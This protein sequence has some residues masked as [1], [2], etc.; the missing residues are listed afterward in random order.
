M[1]GFFCCCLMFAVFP[2]RDL[3]CSY[4]QEQPDR[5]YRSHHEGTGGILCYQFQCLLVLYKTKTNKN[6]YSAKFVDKTRQRRFQEEWSPC[7]TEN[8]VIFS[9]MQTRYLPSARACWRLNCSS[10]NSTFDPCRITFNVAA[11]SLVVNT[12]LLYNYLFN[13]LYSYLGVLQQQQQSSFLAA[14]RS[15]VPQLLKWP[16][17]V[18][19]LFKWPK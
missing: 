13:H 16:N 17:S 7:I 8:S 10:K 15:S 5:L 14:R 3:V 9:L 2:R 6:L 19:Q 1:A 4:V 18:Q 12:Y 11:S